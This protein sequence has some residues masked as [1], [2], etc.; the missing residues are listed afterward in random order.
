MMP[1]HKMNTFIF[2]TIVSLSL[3]A[4]GAGELEFQPLSEVSISI[5]TTPDG[6]CSTIYPIILLLLFK[7]YIDNCNKGEEFNFTSTLSRRRSLQ[8]NSRRALHQDL[9]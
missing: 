4:L 5:T 6:T 7:N 2:L 1:Y 9:S 3:F 8:I